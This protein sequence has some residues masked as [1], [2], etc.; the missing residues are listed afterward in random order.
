[1]ISHVAISSRVPVAP[2]EDHVTL[3]L[4][5]MTATPI[6]QRFLSVVRPSL[7]RSTCSLILLPLHLGLELF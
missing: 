7:I 6:K 5:Y 1:M 3:A 2:R 4:I